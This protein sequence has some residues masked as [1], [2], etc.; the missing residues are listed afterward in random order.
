MLVIASALSIQDPRER[1][2]DGREKA[3][4]FHNRF[5]VEGS[6][7][8]SLVR[9]WDHLRA[10]QRELSGNR[11]RRMC[12]QEYLNYLR[13]REWMDLYSQLRRVAGQLKIRPS[14]LTDG[15]LDTHP[16]HVHR[17]LLAGLLSQIGMRDR[18]TREYRGARDARF[19]IARGSVITRKQ[20][21]WV[22]AAELV[23]TNRLY[24]R[25]VAAIEPEWIEHAGEHL[26]KRSYGDPRWDAKAGRAVCTEQVTLFGL[27]VVSDRKVGYD[28]VDIA[29][30]RAWFITKALVEGEWSSSQKFVARN[31]EFLERIK[32]MAE[33]V[34]R[35][36]LV[37]DE[38]L[39]AFFDDRV[40][41]DVT[42]T[43]HFD[44]WWKTERQRDGSLLDL[45]D[46]LLADREHGA[47]IR[48]DD[49][50]DV[51]QQGEIELPLTYRYAPGQP[52]DGVTVH[53]PLSA[54]NQIEP[55]GFDWQIPGHRREVV[56]MLVRSVPKDI[57]RELTPIAETIDATFARVAD[58]EPGS[59]PLTH[60][61]AVGLTRA[62][63]IR[64]DPAMFNTAVLDPYLRMNFVVSDDAGACRRARC[65]Y[66]PHSDQ[67]TARR[68]STSLDCGGRADRGA[69]GHHDLGRR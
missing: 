18:E 63:G 60:A 69:A 55:T 8:L 59:M 29:A 35:V 36:E 33:R 20:P 32:Q 25:R 3:N 38:M 65:R 48:L 1:P 66:R 30:A 12:R 40:G 51:W 27:P 42:S 41:D 6:D 15:L 58:F 22:M 61:V 9:L 57:R 56:G 19:V 50:P 43:R 53:I 64:I 5:K 68:R 39:F 34:R 46:D 24:A 31:A 67:G 14:R 44:R 49:F 13:V 23:E 54:L 17:A 62:S 7:L 28:R 52:L 4:E 37:D 21:D 16:D 47:G 2:E 26:A 45:T 10:K 11:F